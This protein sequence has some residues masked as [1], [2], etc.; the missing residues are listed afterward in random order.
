MV[1]ISSR[2]SF[3][4]DRNN[5]N[6]DLEHGTIVDRRATMLFRDTVSFLLVLKAGCA[7]QEGTLNTS[8]IPMD[9][10]EVLGLAG[11]DSQPLQQQVSS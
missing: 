8:E 10:A 6:I 4:V 5:P 7:V 9:T 3:Y 2:K 1:L 11:V